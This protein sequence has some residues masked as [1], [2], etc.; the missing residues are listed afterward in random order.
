MTA[1]FIFQEGLRRRR[2]FGSYDV[3]NINSKI[4]PVRFSRS[5]AAKM[6]SYRQEF[7]PQKPSIF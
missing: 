7:P 5:R 6:N 3:P 1:D 4:K 2:T